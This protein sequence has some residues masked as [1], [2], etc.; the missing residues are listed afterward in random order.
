MKN[1]RFRKYLLSEQADKHL[2]IFQFIVGV[3]FTMFQ[4]THMWFN[5]TQGI[6]ISLFGVVIM[7]IGAN[8]FLAWQSNNHHPSKR[9]IRTFNIYVMWLIVHII[10]IVETLFLR[11]SYNQ[12]IA[13]QLDIITCVL[14]GFGYF[15]I[16]IWAIY[17]K[18]S[19][20]DPS[21]KGMV[22]LVSK[23][24]PQIL[25]VIIIF[26]NGGS[27]HSIMGIFL[28]ILTPLMRIAQITLNPHHD[29]NR[30]WLLVSEWSNEITWLMV[31]LAWVI[32]KL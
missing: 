22:G 10:L 24:L 26:A 32:M 11:I 3:L 21:I 6:S 28:P 5:G 18:L 23:S 30:Y 1:N 17:K 19:Y 13:Y 12:P 25:L 14:V 4:T 15:G 27:G 16:L 8:M 31:S 20:Q 29:R 7:F 9:M 2:Y